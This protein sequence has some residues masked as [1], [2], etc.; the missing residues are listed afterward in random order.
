MDE[1]NITNVLS[2]QVEEVIPEVEITQEP[3]ESIESLKAE[4]ETLKEAIRQKNEQQ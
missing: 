4:I 3:V 2:E 1:Q